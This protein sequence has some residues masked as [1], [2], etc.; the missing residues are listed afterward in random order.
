V[1]SKTF[2]LAIADI[3]QLNG[4]AWIAF[5]NPVQ[6]AL[7]V[8]KILV[9][10]LLGILGIVAQTTLSLRDRRWLVVWTLTFTALAIIVACLLFMRG[11]TE[12]KKVEFLVFA[13]VAL[14]NA[15]Y[16]F[17]ASVYALV[18]KRF[19]AVIAGQVNVNNEP[20]TYADVAL[21][22]VDLEPNPVVD[23]KDDLKQGGRYNFHIW[24]SKPGWRYQVVAKH[25]WT[26]EGRSIIFEI[27]A[28]KK[29]G[30]PVISLTA[31]P[32]VVQGPPGGASASA[33]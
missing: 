12:A 19:Q 5:P 7:D 16:A 29:R 20:A 13:V 31:A 2:R 10:A 30:I 9:G 11:L 26:N 18:A 3:R 32:V 8:S 6:H 24:R 14:V 27:V 22:R 17:G 1:D 28:G 33:A 21:M 15:T 25:S 23:R 4:K